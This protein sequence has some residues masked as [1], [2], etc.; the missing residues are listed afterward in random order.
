M[1]QISTVFCCCRVGVLLGTVFAQDGTG[2][3]LGFSVRVFGAVVFFEGFLRETVE[4]E[5]GDGAF[6]ARRDDAPGA[7]RTAPA[8]EFVIFEPD[9]AR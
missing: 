3:R 8:R 5:R 1:T 6:Q 9:H 2:L 4:C 7:V